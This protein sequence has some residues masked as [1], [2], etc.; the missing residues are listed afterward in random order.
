V[1]KM[2]VV[3][4][5]STSGFDHSLVVSSTGTGRSG[6]VGIFWNNKTRVQF[7]HTHNITL[8]LLLQRATVSPGG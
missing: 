5:K 6:G 3:S 4:L 8:M 1:H 7:Y 2:W